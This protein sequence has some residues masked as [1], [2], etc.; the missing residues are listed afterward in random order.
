VV[1]IDVQ[2]RLQRREFTLDV[3]MQLPDRRATAL[4]G[5]SGCGKTTVLRAMA[6]LLH[7]AGRVTVAEQVW[8]DDATGRCMPAHQ[9]AVGYVSQETSLFAHLDVRRNLEFGLKRVGLGSRRV[10][11]DQAV[12]LLNLAALMSRD[13]QGLSGGE[14]QRVAIARALLASPRLLLLDEPLTGLDAPRKAEVLECIRR[15]HEEL[16]MPVIYVSHAMEEVRQLASHLVLM[17]AGRVS[18]SGP[19]ETVLRDAESARLENRPS[20]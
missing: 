16:A 20:I 6:G 3:Q 11:L 2:L 10:S 17:E 1:V 14:R 12:V 19:L 18:A 7:A 5:P 8:Q 15:L 13:T 9:R 4:V